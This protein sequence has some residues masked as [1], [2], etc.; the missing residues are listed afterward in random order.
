LLFI[1]QIYHD[2]LSTECQIYSPG[3]ISWRYVAH[4]RADAVQHLHLFCN[5]NLSPNFRLIFLEISR[6][7]V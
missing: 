2:A 3:F 6:S 5:T 1:T 4:W 7:S